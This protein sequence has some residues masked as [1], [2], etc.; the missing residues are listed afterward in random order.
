MVQIRWTINAKDDLRSI[1][2]YISR[3]SLKYAKLQVERIQTRTK[4][5]NTHIRIGKIV[6]E[7]ND[8]Y[9]RN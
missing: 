8:P 3:D 9:I 7:F 6:P 1:A 4:I 5:L 2:D